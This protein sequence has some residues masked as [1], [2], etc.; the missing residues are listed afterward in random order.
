MERD[1]LPS[2]VCKGIFFLYFYFSKR[3]DPPVT[4]RV[5]KKK[6]FSVQVKNKLCVGF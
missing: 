4:L 3:T 2:T 1:Q 6:E 5:C